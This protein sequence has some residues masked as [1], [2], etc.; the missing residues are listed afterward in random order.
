MLSLVKRWYQRHFSQPGTIEF[1]VVLLATFII[2]YYFMW[3]VGP[4]V[5][6]LCLAF[7]LDWPVEKLKRRFG[8]SREIGSC[9][10]MVLF[11]SILVSLAVLVVPNVIKQGAEFYNSIVSFSI[12]DPEKQAKYDQQSFTDGMLGLSEEESSAAK[13]A[14]QQGINTSNANHTGNAITPSSSSIA[15][16]M[17]DNPGHN[18]THSAL[19][20]MSDSSSQFSSASAPNQSVSSR[21]FNDLAG[22]QSRPVIDAASQSRIAGAVDGPQSRAAFDLGSAQSRIAKALEGPQSRATFDSGA[23]Q[24]LA[25]NVSDSAHS[26]MLSRVAPQGAS[27]LPSTQSSNV[28]NDTTI[29]YIST[30][31]ESNPISQGA[32]GRMN[33]GNGYRT[34]TGSHFTDK[35]LQGGQ[36]HTFTNSDGYQIKVI[37]GATATRT[38]GS[39]GTEDGQ[40]SL[41]VNDF[42]I[43]VAHELNELVNN[44]PEPMPTM[45]TLTTLEE[46][47]S[48]IRVAATNKIADLMRTQLMPSVVNAFTW[49]VYAIIVPI[50]TFLM[51]YNKPVLQKR[52]LTFILPNNQQLMRQF[53][54]SMQAQISGY[55]RGKILHIIIIAAANSLAFMLMGMNYALLLGVGVGL[56]VVIPYVGAVIIAVPVVMV[57][58]F[59]FGFSPELL[60]VLILYTVIQLLDSNVLTPMLFS[61][62]M[63]LDAFSILSAILIFGN[64]W[65]FW[66]V[67]FAI[68]L[69]TFV[70]TLIIGWP[71]NDPHDEFG[72]PQSPKEA[73]EEAAL[74]LRELNIKDVEKNFNPAADKDDKDRI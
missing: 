20:Q 17:A 55:I 51:L 41:T 44:L 71:N 43:H 52:A 50:F 63:N 56:S 69:A 49:L 47:V 7:C 10:V 3:L 31:D 35:L 26:S 57:A 34:T 62:A 9:I 40:F 5:V 8:I 74:T 58:V 60:W 42:D 53:W 59:Q 1:A 64:L 18:A 21:S 23:A 54:P 12:V 36:T 29:I 24:S 67:F 2:I 22:P 72:N 70:K 33:H 61:K 68:P 19:S 28:D 65:G 13:R 16:G 32:N 14:A 46:G 27:A 37:N 39:F 45:L 25:P 30:P 73:A 48:K 66:G 11:S 6:A 4:I 15:A 38:V